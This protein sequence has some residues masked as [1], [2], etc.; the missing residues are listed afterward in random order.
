MTVCHSLNQYEKAMN[1][2]LK[3]I[4]K[5]VLC[6]A[7]V[8]T[9]LAYNYKVKHELPSWGDV[10]TAKFWINSIIGIIPMY[11]LVW[12]CGDKRLL[13]SEVQVICFVV[14]TLWSIVYGII[15]AICHFVFHY[16]II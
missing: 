14:F 8:A 15:Y 9:L 7:A 2:Y 1:K 11:T 13:Y 12:A 4:I 6:T 3:R 16:D 5:A 10:L